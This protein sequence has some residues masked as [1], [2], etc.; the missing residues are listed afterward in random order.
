MVWRTQPEVLH[1]FVST[2][3]EIL[4]QAIRNGGVVHLAER[5]VSTLLEILDHVD[6]T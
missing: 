4:G 3:L 6:A 5:S 1:M 2:L